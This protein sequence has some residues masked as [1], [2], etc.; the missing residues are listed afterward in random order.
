MKRKTITLSA[1]IYTMLRRWVIMLVTFAVVFGVG[2]GLTI[3]KD[4]E[5]QKENAAAAAKA[6][7]AAEAN[8]GLQEKNMEDV[9]AY[10]K[11]IKNSAYMNLDP[12]NC[13][14]H[15]IYYTIN[16]KEQG[17]DSKEYENKNVKLYQY[18]SVYY[19]SDGF[20]EEILSYKPE[21]E[22]KALYEVVG[23]GRSGNTY[24]FTILYTDDYYVKDLCN[25]IDTS[26]KEK[27]PEWYSLAGEFEFSRGPETDKTVDG[28]TNGYKKIQDSKLSALAT[29]QATV[30]N[31]AT[32]TTTVTK[33]GTMVEKILAVFAIAFVC[34]VIVGFI[35]AMFRRRFDTATDVYDLTGD[36]VLCVVKNDKERGLDKMFYKKDDRYQ[37]PGTYLSILDKS[38]S[39]SSVNNVYL[40]NCSG[41]DLASI[42]NRIS[43]QME[44]INVNYVPEEDKEFYLN[45]KENDAVIIL[46]KSGVT[47][48]RT[49]MRMI[50]HLKTLGIRFRGVIFAV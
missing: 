8:K 21:Y 1:I 22:D 44:N 20:T 30:T 15:Y 19:P 10:E 3:I 27:S 4:K 41:A 2:M 29:A 28:I 35:V 48:K 6:K 45:A 24:I 16:W 38:L 49:Y 13:H 33:D 34:A 18:M 32:T 36:G 14:M 12:T 7:L 5:K 42:G 47:E 37:N 31:V 23:L 17:L 26:L 9:L 11:Y 43:E 39:D 25:V 40:Y 46:I 50:D